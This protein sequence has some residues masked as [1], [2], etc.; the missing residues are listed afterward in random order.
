MRT[1]L[2]AGLFFLLFCFQLLAAEVEVVWEG[3]A[4][5]PYHATLEFRVPSGWK[6]YG[7]QKAWPELSPGMV[8]EKR[9]NLKDVHLE[10]PQGAQPV[11]IQGKEALAYTRPFLVDVRLTPRYEDRVSILKGNLNY[12]ACAEQCLPLSYP[13]DWMHQGVN[14]FFLEVLL[15]AA[16]GGLILNFMPCV[17][18]ILSL[19]L[20]GLINAHGDLRKQRQKLIYTLLGSLTFFLLFGVVIFV[21][22]AL[23]Q[24]VGWGMHFQDPFFTNFFLWLLLILSARFLGLI[25]VRSPD[26]SIPLPLSMKGRA[27]V[28]GLTL[29]VLATPCTAPYLG[30]ASGLALT[31]P[32]MQLL[33]IFVALW[34]GFSI[35]YFLMLTFPKLL[36][37]ILP[38][39]GKWMGVMEKILGVILLV[40][41]FFVGFYILFNQT[42]SVSLPFFVLGI[43]GFIFFGVKF[44]PTW[45]RKL[46]ALSL[47]VLVLPSLSFFKPVS[48]AGAQALVQSPIDLEALSGRAEKGE[49]ILVKVGAKWCATCHLNDRVL[50][51]G[52]LKEAFET[53]KIQVMALD[54]TSRNP[55]I[56]EM[57]AEYDRSGI[58]FSLLFGPK[59]PQG[60]V[61]PE[62]LS[63]EIVLRA[64]KEV[65]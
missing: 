25:R 41:A 50:A 60:K 2:K 16:L 27:F 3:D 29:A 52:D 22:R 11:M 19:K 64:L 40:F 61:L 53:H 47:M 23:G 5:D 26:I 33:S 55:K 32:L 49:V 45:Q 8:L 28:D 37:K 17:L 46:L 14:F 30:V 24:S 13:L 63:R 10:W 44:F 7:I 12:V 58:P 6:V 51:G 54:F 1:V 36:V 56:T 39:P 62:L 38:K 21:L 48:E 43:M 34:G 59:Q 15:M 42:G 35:P 18:P 57:I 20:F 31:M 9:K 65:I 4:H